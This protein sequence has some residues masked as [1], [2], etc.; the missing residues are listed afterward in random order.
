[1]KEAGWN[2]GMGICNAYLG[3]DLRANSFNDPCKVGALP[4]GIAVEQSGHYFQII[5]QTSF[6]SSILVQTMLWGF[7]LHI[8]DL[9]EEMSALSV[10]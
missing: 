8:L 9:T 6:T 2:F 3:T 10:L 5:F 1:M 7:Y 4:V